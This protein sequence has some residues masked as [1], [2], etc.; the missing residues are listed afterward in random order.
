MIWKLTRQ[1]WNFG[2]FELVGLKVKTTK[3]FSAETEQKMHKSVQEFKE[4]F[5]SARKQIEV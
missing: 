3:D 2:W 5:V 4:C 1:F